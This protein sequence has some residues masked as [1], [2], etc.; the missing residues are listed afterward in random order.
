M[1]KLRARY[2]MKGKTMKLIS[3]LLTPWH[4]YC[5]H[6]EKQRVATHEKVEAERK[7]RELQRE[8]L[9]LHPTAVYIRRSDGAH[10]SLESKVM[11]Y[12]SKAGVV[13]HH[14]SLDYLERVAR[15]STEVQK[16]TRVLIGRFW[17]DRNHDLDGCDYRLIGADGTSRIL[18]ANRLECD[19]KFSGDTGDKLAGMILNDLL[20]NLSHVELI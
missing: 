20:Y 4:Q 2:V 19:I 18:W 7:R 1:R 9:L 15:G 16:G 8:K 13:I 5:A 11:R 12:L 10:T 3:I 6:V 14:V 17:Q